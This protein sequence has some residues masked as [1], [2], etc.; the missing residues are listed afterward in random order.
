VVELV[1]FCPFYGDEQWDLSPLKATN[2]VNGVGDMAREE[3]YTLRDSG[4]QRVQEAM[5]RRIVHELAGFDNVYYEICNEPYF[6]GVTLPWQH[7]IADVI[8]EAE[9]ARPHRHL[10]AQNIANGSA[11]VDTPHPAI[12]ILNFHYAA[13]PDAVTRNYHLGRVIADDETG[14]RGTA[15][16]PYRAEAWHFLMAG[17][18][19]FDHLDYSFTAQ[20]EDGTFPLPEGQPGGGGRAFRHQMGVLKRF[21]E[22]FDFVRMA[23]STDTV[24]SSTGGVS[25]RAL[26]EP[27]RAFAV[28]VEGGTQVGIRLEA[29]TGRYVAEWVNPRT[30]ETIRGPELDHPGG[31]LALSSPAYE[32]D[33]ALRLVRRD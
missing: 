16:R 30:G 15:D 31:E 24:R 14:F 8:W 6:G 25:C 18:A 1:L 20:H 22:S 28:Y 13:P 21:I 7:R 26:V 29:P 9:T 11:L 17:G 4:L 33:I 23:P 27:G 12:S 3:V 2:N 10:I 5:V 19:V 32:E